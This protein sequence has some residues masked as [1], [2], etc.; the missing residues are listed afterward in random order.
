MTTATTSQPAQALAE[1]FFLAISTQDRSALAQ[2]LGP[3]ATWTFPGHN[4]L[5]GTVVGVDQIAAKAQLIGRYG[6]HV[7]FEYVLFGSGSFIIELHDTGRRGDLVLDEHL[8]TVCTVQ[9]G[10]IA[11]ADTHLSDLVMMDAYFAALP[12]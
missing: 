2:V 3:D 10:R 1:R 4:A 7:G 6:V 5:S 12:D 11:S 9:D 8:A